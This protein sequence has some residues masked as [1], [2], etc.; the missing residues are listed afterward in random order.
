MQGHEQVCGITGHLLTVNVR[1]APR[2]QSD[3]AK[4]FNKEE[5]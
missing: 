3:C 5:A 1:F 4:T 2:L